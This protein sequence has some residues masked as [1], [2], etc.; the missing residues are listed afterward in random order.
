VRV[1]DSIFNCRAEEGS[2]ALGWRHL[3]SPAELGIERDRGRAGEGH[4]CN[5]RDG[6]K[7]SDAEQKPDHCIP[8]A[9][10]VGTVE[11]VVVKVG[12]VENVPIRLAPERLATESG[13]GEVGT[14]ELR[15]YRRV[16]SPV[17]P[18]FSI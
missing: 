16:F 3:A 10:K 11:V 5:E 9:G 18:E 17:I 4:W 12:V 6:R 14:G 8:G 13:A 7:R 15:N 2:P 1:L